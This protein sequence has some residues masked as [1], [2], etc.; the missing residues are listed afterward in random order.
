MYSRRFLHVFPPTVS[1]LAP[2]LPWFVR[3]PP[4]RS[5]LQSTRNSFTKVPLRAFHEPTMER[6]SSRSTS[7]TVV[8]AEQTP[9]LSESASDHTLRGNGPADNESEWSATAPMGLPLANGL[10]G[11]VASIYQRAVRST[12]EHRREN[13]DVEGER[14]GDENVMPVSRW[15]GFFICLSVWVLLFLQGNAPSP[16]FLYKRHQL[17]RAKPPTCRG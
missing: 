12:E 15:R 2:K 11:R 16:R 10:L 5:S 8:P 17:R 3:E 6:S 7:S 14:R 1:F 4:T 13:G 9:L